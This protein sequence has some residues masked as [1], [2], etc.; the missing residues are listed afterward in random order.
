MR[1]D[2][3]TPRV[4]RVG[5]HGLK[6]GSRSTLYGR[7]TQH[8]GTS[9]GGGNHRGSVFRLH[10]GK[11]LINRGLFDCPTWAKGSTASREVTLAER[12]LEQAVSRYIGE[13]RIV[14]LSIPD[15]PGPA[16]RRAYVERNAIGLLAG[17]EA[18]SEN[19]LGRLTENQAIIRSFLW[20]VNH[21]DH[22]PDDGFVD[23]L[24]QIV[25]AQTG[26]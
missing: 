22:A 21:I 2:G 1:S 19:W 4:V 15:E 3:T 10:V 14:L 7:L 12:E 6:E 13:M 26:S 16:S 24:E 5:T 17:K 23:Y 9:S 18:P 25:T 20:N 11:A 8:R